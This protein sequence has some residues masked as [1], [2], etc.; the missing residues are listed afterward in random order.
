MTDSILLLA[1]KL[2]P[3][4]FRKRLRSIRTVWPP[5]G[6]VRF[7][8]L[9]RVQ[10][11]SRV[12]GTDRGQCIDRFYIDNFLMRHSMDIQGSV[13]EVADNTYTK[14]F[15]G[16]RIL[17]SHVLHVREGNPKATVIADLSSKNSIASESFDCI[18]LTQTLQFIYDLKSAMKTLHRIL[19]DDG[20]LLATLPG[21]SQISR[22]DMD[23]WGDFWRFTTSSAAR[24]FEEV[25]SPGDII[26]ESNGN[27][28]VANAFL[29]GLA[30]EDLTPEEMGYRDDDYQMLITVRAVKRSKLGQGRE[31]SP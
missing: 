21:I 18:I 22:Y 25:F 26:L 29:Q 19:K 6:W 31:L 7:G 4:S 17:Q 14:R 9:R 23:R 10:P 3:A 2:I 5:V 8:N 15:G 13:L 27:V 16:N 12:F 28:L 24:L 20:V 11:V 30:V 1:R